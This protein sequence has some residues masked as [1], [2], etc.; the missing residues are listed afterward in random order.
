MRSLTSWRVTSESILMAATLAALVIANS[1]YGGPFLRLL[2]LHLGPALAGH[3]PLTCAGWINDGLMAVFFFL[4]GL[5]LK[6]ELLV[7]ELRNWRRAGLPVAAALGGM[8]VPAAI[9]A[10]VN[11]GGPGGRGWGIPM[12]TDIV[13]ALAALRLSGVK[14]PG[15]VAFLLALAIADDLGA[16]LVIAACYAERLHWLYL[17]GAVATLAC[18]GVANRARVSA[19]WTYAALGIVLWWCV[20]GSGVHPTIA[21]VGLAFSIPSSGTPDARAVRGSLLEA[22]ERCLQ[23]WVMFGIVPLF[24]LAN[25]GAVLDRQS[26]ASMLNPVPL[27]VVA[28]LV[29]GKPVGIL[30]T[31]WLAVRARVCEL[32]AAI[33]WAEVLGAACLAGIGFTMSLFIAVLAFGD[34]P[35]TAQARCGILT[36]SLVSTLIGIWLL[37][38]RKKSRVL[39]PVR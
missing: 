37:H 12:S 8:A 14:T 35:L 3:D 9:Y 7:G 21:G 10:I 18:A 22:M 33:S 24:A 19:W 32:P 36:A 29:V 30:L 16:I 5:E 27:G 34:S 11:A 4:I 31:S 6:R 15:L 25:A 17:L 26:V 39:R 1:A 28:G 20:L 13:F 2:A 23:P 38:A